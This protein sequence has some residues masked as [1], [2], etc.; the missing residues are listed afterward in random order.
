ML[1]Q[2]VEWG[3]AVA[4]FFGEKTN[5]GVDTVSHDMR[6]LEETMDYRALWALLPYDGYDQTTQLF[7]NKRSQGFVLEV[8]PLMGANEETV[9]ILSS[10]ITDTLPKNAD[11]QFM[12]WGSDKIGETLDQFE[13]ER[14]GKG[15]IFEW[16][17]KKRTDYFKQGIYKSLTSQNTFVLRDFRLFISVSLPK[18]QDQD[19]TSELIKLREDFMSSMKS[20]QMYSYSLDADKFIS[21]VSDILH[22]ASNPYPTK[23][24]WNPYDSLSMQMGNPENCI[25]IFKDRLQFE[26]PDETWE[27]RLLSVKEYPQSSGQWDMTNAIGKLFN[28]GF[29]VP[30]PFITTLSISLV[31]EQKAGYNAPL[32][33][34][35]RE[36][37]A[38]SPNAKWMPN[39]QKEYEDWEFVKRRLSE[40]DK[41]A[42]C[43]YSVLLFAKADQAGFAERKVRD[44][45]RSNGWKLKKS[46]FLQ[47]QS[48]LATLPMMMSEGMF[49]D[50]K[51]MGRIQTM[52]VFNAVNIAPLQG[53]CKGTKTPSLI[54]PGRRGQ[55]ATFNP[56]DN[57]EGNFNIAIAAAS[58]KGKSA[59]TQEYIMALRGSGGRV[60]VIDIG[61]SYEKTCHIIGGTFIEFATHSTISLNPFTHITNFDVSLTML[62]PLLAAM[63]HPTSRAS[64]EE[65]VY[66]ERALKAAW[67]EKKNEAS[68]TTVADWL[69]LEEQPICKN[70]SHLL[71]SYTKDGMY[72]HYFE[73]RSNVDLSNQ[74]VVLELQELKAK[75]DLQRIVMLVLMYHISDAMYLGDRSQY[76]SCIIDEAWD[77]FSGENDG[78]AQ[79][80]ETGYRTARRYSANFVT[81]VQSINDYFKN[82]MT[83]ASFENS[84]TKIILGQTSE[85]IDLAKKNEYLSMDAFSE[86]LYKSLKKTDEYSECIIKSLSGLSVNLIIF[87]PYARILYSSKGQEFEAVKALEQQGHSLRDAI[88]I[89]AR[90]LSCK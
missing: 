79:F 69:S 73:G 20:I 22:P 56:F 50:L 43:Y 36:K 87:D 29:Q 51:Q 60:W 46:S 44:L 82:A 13:Q 68:I 48:F 58:G 35:S 33:S 15:E 81:I 83:I 14:S 21:L 11:L 54:L 67:N 65:L 66:I 10:L 39:I 49:S 3:H 80:I 18:K 26:L 42:K 6:H 30:C 55:I 88:E 74:F 40:G 62:K 75:K 52:T 9:N 89:I 27:A 34:A 72:G 17:A 23:S 59:F 47:L 7:L 8:T 70:L 90:G 71:Y 64:D 76:K 41:L 77:L 24:R 19:F 2:F 16:L 38:R 25:R 57:T 78:A 85:A 32:Q 84:D 4:S 28:D 53:E 5:F 86:R 37:S 63:A 31:D 12:L 45:Y 61:R 1:N